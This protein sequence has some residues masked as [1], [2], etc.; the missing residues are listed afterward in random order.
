MRSWT[1][2]RQEPGDQS[3]EIED[4]RRI[5]DIF[6]RFAPFFKMYTEYVKNLNQ[7]TDTICNL[8]KKNQKFNSIV[9]EVSAMPE[10]GGLPIQHHMLEPFQRIP[11]YKLLFN[12]YVGKL[13]PDSPDRVDAQKALESITDAAMHANEELKRIEKFEKLLMVQ[14]CL[15]GVID[16]VSPTRELLKEGKVVK[17]SARSGDHQDRYLFLV[18]TQCRMIKGGF[19]LK[20]LIFLHFQYSSATFFFYVH[21]RASPVVLLTAKAL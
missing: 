21:L 19:F 6:V 7:S 9:N 17:I 1:R 4:C 2:A 13:P 14:D 16:L 5:G 3:K 10:C 12:R 8:C 18:R 15:G 20:Q 11:K